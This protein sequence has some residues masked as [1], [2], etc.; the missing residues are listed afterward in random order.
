MNEPRIDLGNVPRDS[1][2]KKDVRDSNIDYDRPEQFNPQ[3]PYR[4]FL[5]L[6]PI[7]ENAETADQMQFHKQVSLELQPKIR[8]NVSILQELSPLH[9][10]Y[11]DGQ[12]LTT[13]EEKRLSAIVES[14]Q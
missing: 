1:S 14:L 6:H 4:V 9:Q 10:K 5:A 3:S 13:E 12:N 2:K 11:V 8:A 7:D